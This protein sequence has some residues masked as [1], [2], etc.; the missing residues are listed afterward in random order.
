VPLL[1][2]GGAIGEHVV[3]SRRVE[4]R[5][6]APTILKLLGLDPTDLRAVQVE[7]TRSLPL[8]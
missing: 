6:I 2:S 5:Q 3:Q 7:H 1:V 4:T 8:D